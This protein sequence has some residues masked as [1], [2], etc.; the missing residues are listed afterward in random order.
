MNFLRNLMSNNTL[1]DTVSSIKSS[2]NTVVT[3]VMGL[4]SLGAVIV[5]I[6]LAYKF[7][8]ATDEGKRKNAKMQLIYAIIAVIALVLFTVIVPPII[9]KLTTMANGES[10]FRLMF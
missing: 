9:T 7:F 1:Q 5:A 6:M 8:T 4:L 10:M 2:V 3:A